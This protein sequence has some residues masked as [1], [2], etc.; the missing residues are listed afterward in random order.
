MKFFAIKD[1]EEYKESMVLLEKF[2]DE[3][4]KVITELASLKIVDIKL[5]DC[6]ETSESSDSSCDRRRK[7]A[8]RMRGFKRIFGG[9]GR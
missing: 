4:K 5:E 1:Q 7:R 2:R 3:I 6:S 9:R 8:R